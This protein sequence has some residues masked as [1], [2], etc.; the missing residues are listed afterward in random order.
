MNTSRAWSGAVGLAIAVWAG[1]GCATS[2]GFRDAFKGRQD[3]AWRIVREQRDAWRWAAGGGLEIRA[4]P[5]NMWGPANDAR[6]VWVRPVPAPAM[7]PVT[8]TATVFNRPT[9][10][11]EQVDLVWYYND[12]YQVKIGQELVDGKLSIVMGREEA[13]RTRTIA[14]LPISAD[15]VDLRLRA[16]KMNIEGFYRVAGTT[17]WIRAGTCD[18]PAHGAPHVALEVYQ[19]PAAVERWARI[20]NLRVVQ[21]R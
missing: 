7:G 20:T 16:V 15:T 19:G 17:E 13:D 9:E 6:N 21:E 10:Q 3:P 18:L 5:G 14:I 11:Y 1:S 4:L 8:V 12:S 2:S